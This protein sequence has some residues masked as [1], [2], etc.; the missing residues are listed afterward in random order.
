MPH[1]LNN[2]LCKYHDSVDS[3]RQKFS[4]HTKA[5]WLSR[6]SNTEALLSIECTRIF[7]T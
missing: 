7:K 2:T 4:L 3:L 1:R 5:V 6:S